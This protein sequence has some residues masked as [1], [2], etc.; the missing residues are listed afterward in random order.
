[1][2]PLLEDL[3]QDYSIFI[4][5]NPNIEMIG[6]QTFSD[7]KFSEIKGKIQIKNDINQV[8]NNANQKKSEKIQNKKNINQEKDYFINLKKFI[9]L[10]MIARNLA[11][12]L[13]PSFLIP[14]K[15]FNY[16]N[17]DANHLPETFNYLI[18]ICQNDYNI[19][20]LNQIWEKLDGTWSI[21]EFSEVYSIS[22]DSLREI[23]FFLWKTNLIFLRMEYFPWDR[24]KTTIKAPLFL[25]E[26]SKENLLLI[27]KFNSKK[28]I[29]II[30]YI[31]DGCSYTNLVK[32]FDITKTKLNSYLS[33]LLQRQ[34]IQREDYKPELEVIPEDLI[35]LLSLQGFQKEDFKLLSDL[36]KIL[37]GTRSIRSAALR[38]Q[39]DPSRI[40]GLLDKYESAVK[41]LT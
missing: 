9:F 11:E 10:R 12:Y 29:Q 3:E 28:I 33:E 26:G 21:L 13:L 31:G 39:I 6:G 41:I 37:N 2:D 14:E 32:N 25:D 35:P 20:F 5:N 22:I 17:L 40:K 27:N 34:I 8:K 23:F 1:I 19:S 36:A 18:E 16:H 38:L 7:E 24:F 30:K 15:R 4:N